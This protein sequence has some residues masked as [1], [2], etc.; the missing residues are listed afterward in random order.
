VPP[1]LRQLFWFCLVL[2]H[3]IYRMLCP[4]VLWS[5]W[6]SLGRE[7]FGLGVCN[8]CNHRAEAF[9]LLFEHIYS[10]TDS[11]HAATALIWTRHWKPLEGS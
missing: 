1:L 4:C 10:K 6:W 9:A 3:L 2:R 7:R 11:N 8:L 5:S